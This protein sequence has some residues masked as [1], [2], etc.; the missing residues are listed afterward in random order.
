MLKHMHELQEWIEPLL[1]TV[2]RKKRWPFHASQKI[3]KKGSRSRKKAQNWR[4]PGHSRDQ[5]AMKMTI[6]YGM[7]IN[8]KRKQPKDLLTIFWRTFEQISKGWQSK[9][10]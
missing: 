8:E 10:H 7:Q 6:N 5:Q 9:H 2:S 1:K 3:R 4:M